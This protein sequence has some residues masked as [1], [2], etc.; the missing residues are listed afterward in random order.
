MDAMETT[1]EAK[2]DTSY[3]A[4]DDGPDARLRRR[5][6][7]EA[8]KAA[9]EQEKGE[10]DNEALLDESDSEDQER[11][12]EQGETPRGTSRRTHPPRRRIRSQRY[13]LHLAQELTKIRTVSH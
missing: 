2:L 12:M 1:G 5:E 8:Q 13:R 6:R 11:E 9:A 3:E 10:E 4:D 7:R